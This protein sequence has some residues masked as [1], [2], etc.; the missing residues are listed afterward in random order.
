M[1]NGYKPP[2][3]WGCIIAFITVVPLLLL[4]L[5]VVILN[6]GGCEGVMTPCH[7][8]QSPLLAVF[9]VA[10]ISCFGLAWF[11]NALLDRFRS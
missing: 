10:L 7:R 3:N 1:A 8:D 9:A 6:S 4:I 11:I 2:R 5:L